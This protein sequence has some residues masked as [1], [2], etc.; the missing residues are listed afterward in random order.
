MDPE[1][2]ADLLWIARAGLKAPLPLPW[3]PCQTGEDGELFYFNFETGESV[4]DHPCDEFHR[5]MYREHK[6]EKE[7]RKATAHEYEDDED[8]HSESEKKRKK[9]KKVFGRGSVPIL[10]R[11]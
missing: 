3:K 8:R 1:Q 7:A 9:K 4:W 5:N 10:V 11:L 2:D 6:A